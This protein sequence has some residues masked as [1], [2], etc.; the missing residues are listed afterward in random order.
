[1]TGAETAF[2]PDQTNPIRAELTSFLR[3]KDVLPFEFLTTKTGISSLLAYLGTGQGGKTSSLLNILATRANQMHFPTVEACVNQFR[4]I[5]HINAGRANTAEH[6]QYDNPAVYGQPNTWFS[7]EPKQ[8]NKCDEYFVVS[9][10]EKFKPYFSSELQR[11]WEGF[12]GPL[13]N[14]DPAKCQDKKAWGDVMGWILGQKLRGFQT[15][16]GPLQFTNTI[17]L[18]GIA[19]EPSPEFMAQWIASNREYGA[20]AGLKLLGFNLSKHASSAAVQAAFLCFYRWLDHFLTNADKCDLHF[21]PIFAE[22]LLCKVARWQNR[23][24]HMG[25]NYNLLEKAETLFE[26]EEWTPGGNFE[27]HTNFPIPSCREYPTSVFQGIVDG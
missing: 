3:L 17:A 7:A 21:G 5:Q 25:R 12:L 6:I 1:M 23:L 19:S 27:D 8:H 16:L 13:A 24:L 14:A 22:Q 9:L 18:V 4:E 11:S 15:G 26:P 20:F 2:D 10:E